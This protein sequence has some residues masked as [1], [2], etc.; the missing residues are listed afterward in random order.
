[1]SWFTIK[2]LVS[3]AVISAFFVGVTYWSNNDIKKRQLDEGE[4]TNAILSK[5]D[6]KFDSL[7]KKHEDLTN[8]IIAQTNLA[9]KMISNDMKMISNDIN[10]LDSRFNRL[11]TRLDR[12]EDSVFKLGVRSYGFYGSGPH[13]ACSCRKEKFDQQDPSKHDD[14]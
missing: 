4:L 13:K 8:K 11:G 10:A 14:F 2:D 9:L 5:L 7:D 3:P 6:E 12:V 1:M